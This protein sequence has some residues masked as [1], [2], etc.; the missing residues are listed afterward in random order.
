MRRY[1]ILILDDDSLTGRAIAGIAEFMG[2][3][4]KVTTDFD[5]CLQVI[6]EWQPSH[7]IL[8]LIMPDKDGVEV[9]G[10]LGKM[11]VDCQ[12]ILTSGAGQQLLEAASRSAVAH[13]LKVAGILPKPFNPKLFRELLQAE[14]TQLGDRA[15]IEPA[16]QHIVPPVSI[17][18][19]QHAIENR[20]IYLAYQPKI[21][22]LSGALTGFEALAR[23]Q[24][25]EYGFVPP[26]Q[27]IAMAEKHG[28]I[29]AIT[30]QVFEQALAFLQH[31]QH[32]Q[33]QVF[34]LKN[35]VLSVNI[36]AKSLTNLDLFHQIEAL[37]EAHAISPKQLILE[38]TETAAMDDP[39]TS[40]D[41]LTRLRMRGFRLSIDDFGTGFSSM[42]ALVRM[43]FSEVKVDKSFVMTSTTSRESRLVIKATIE[44]AHSLELTVTAEGI[45]NAAV[46]RQLQEMGCDMAQGYYIGRPMSEDAVD[47]W[48]DERAELL[49]KQRLQSLR[50]LKLLDSP[51]ELRFDRI[52][53]LAKRLFRVDTTLITLIDEDR[54]WIKSSNGFTRQQ[55]KRSEAFCN[56]TIT[57][58]QILVITDARQDARFV[59]NPM[60]T[61]APFVRFYAG[62]PIH[63][64]TGEKLGA[65]CLNHSKPRGFSEREKHLLTALAQ[66]VDDEIA[67]NPLLSEDHLTGLLNRQGFEQRAEKLLALYLQHQQLV[68]MCY[69]DLDN[70]KLIN[71]VQGKHAGDDALINFARLL[72]QAFG[73]TEL[74]ARYGGD[75]FIMLSLHPL[76]AETKEALHQLEAE[77]AEYNASQNPDLRIDYSVGMASTKQLDA[78]DLQSLYTL[79]DKNL[80]HYRQQRAS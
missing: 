24:H 10:E 15:L 49:E 21:N 41:T 40:L 4:V 6:E 50:S 36:S 33:S 3:A 22:V 17:A 48:L 79:S 16:R 64:V 66:L 29:D 63:A 42:L 5:S 54:Q 14:D 35:L 51:A 71:Q 32:V 47:D 55:I 70:F 69:F 8:D 56:Q 58:D 38:L 37:C 11:G 67:S 65:L 45:E 27:F 26:D 62:C 77:V 18:D 30:L 76:A 43:P 39:V 73:D 61:Q 9:L 59:D 78:I 72:R 46:L 57:Q 20:H 34:A 52:T 80:Q 19:L 28:L 53:R 31:K 1:R 2:L 60:V 7:L 75:E 68:T 25:S 13:G 12:V 44:L 74:L 23:W